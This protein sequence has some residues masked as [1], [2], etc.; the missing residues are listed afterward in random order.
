MMRDEAAVYLANCLDELP[1]TQREALRLRYVEGR[2]LK[3]IADSMDKSDMAVAGLLTR[4]L[5]ALRT[6][7]VTDSSTGGS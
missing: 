1:E 7:M 2:S 3:E 4:G 5:K 6:R